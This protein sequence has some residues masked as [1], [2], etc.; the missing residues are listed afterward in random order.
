MLSPQTHRAGLLAAVT[1]ALFLTPDSLLIHLSMADSWTLAFWRGLMLGCVMLAGLLV[2]HGRGLPGLLRTNGRTGLLIS[3]VYAIDILCFV[4]A[5][6]QTTVA[7]VMLALATG[8]MFAALFSALLMRERT[9]PPTW[10]AIALVFGG[11]ALA[12]SQNTTLDGVHGMLLALM[13]AAGTG[14]MFT[15]VR[16]EPDVDMTPSVMLGGFIVAAAVLP[17]ASPLDIA[18]D[19]IIFVVLQAVVVGPGA[20][21]LFLLS[22]R[23]ISSVEMV[24]VMRLETV[25]APALAWAFLGETASIYTLAGLLLVVVTLFAHSAWKLKQMSEGS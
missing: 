17:A 19:K 13:A 10:I 16:R 25:L 4:L 14:L 5:V 9:L 22:L 7:N 15:L 20:Y 23:Q 6:G 21:I 18:P 8:P 3:V 2:I 1:G 11:V 12:M 24:M